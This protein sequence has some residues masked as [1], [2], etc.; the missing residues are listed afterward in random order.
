MY[1]CDH[2]VG[3]RDRHLGVLNRC[4]GVCNRNFG[5]GNCNLGICN[6]RVGVSDH[7]VG[8]DRQFC[9]KTR[10][11]AIIGKDLRQTYCENVKDPVE[12]QLPRSDR[13]FIT[14]RV[15]KSGDRISFAQLDD[16][17]LDLG[18]SSAIEALVS[19]PLGVHAN[20]QTYSLSS[21]IASKT[22]GLSSSGCFPCNPRSSALHTS[23]QDKPSSTQSC[24]LIIDSWV[25]VNREFVVGE[26]E[27]HVP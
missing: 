27:S 13:L 10:F 15:E 2:R 19:K 16:L 14:L 24:R 8:G 26:R 1:V 6:L 7:D 22:D 11:L 20:G 21:S 9:L 12:V 5:A 23:A 18:H 17:P 4:V 3:I 25:N